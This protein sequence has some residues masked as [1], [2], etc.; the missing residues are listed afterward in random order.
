[1]VSGAESAVIASE[2]AEATLIPEED[3][4]NADNSELR[5]TP[6]TELIALSTPFYST[7]SP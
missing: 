7:T 1:L 4:P 2:T 3:D 5:L 6:E